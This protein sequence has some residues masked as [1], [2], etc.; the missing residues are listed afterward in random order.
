MGVSAH[1]SVDCVGNTN[2]VSEIDIEKSQIKLGAKPLSK[3]ACLPFLSSLSHLI[4]HLVEVTLQV[5]RIMAIKAR[6][7]VDVIFIISSVLVIFESNF[8]PIV[9][10]TWIP[11]DPARYP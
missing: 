10:V 8:I 11:D 2:R 9:F 5:S 1:S 3:K 6:G 4:R 7:I